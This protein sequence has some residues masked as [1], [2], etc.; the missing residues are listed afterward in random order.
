M[1]IH[2]DFVGGNIRVLREDGEHIYLN[3]ELR[4]TQ[5][6]WFYWAFCVEGAE[7][8]TITFHFPPIRLGYYGPAV[9]H[10]LKTWHWLRDEQMK[11]DSF[12]YT[13]GA[14]EERVYF[15]HNMQ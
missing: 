9:S 15:A 4:D 1:R 11:I 7:D 3:N 12:T 8:K 10:D 14:D 13:F 5:G 6:D 2:G